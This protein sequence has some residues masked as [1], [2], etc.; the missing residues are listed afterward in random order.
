MAGDDLDLLA[1]LGPALEQDVREE[2]RR[3]LGGITVAVRRVDGALSEVSLQPHVQRHASGL[4]DVD[5]KEP[6]R[7]CRF[8]RRQAASTAGATRRPRRTSSRSPSGS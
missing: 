2:L 4:L 5:E 1:A 3:D 6:L 7:L 8:L